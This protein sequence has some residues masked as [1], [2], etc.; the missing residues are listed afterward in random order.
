MKL[1][2]SIASMYP[3]ETE[4]SLEFLGKNGVPVTEIFFNSP[5]ELEPRF[6]SL[7]NKIRKTHGIEIASIHPCGSVAEPYFLFS[8]YKRRYEEAFDFYKKYYLAAQKLGAGTVVIHGDSYAGSIPAEEYCRRL[9]AMNEEAAKYGVTISHENVN[10]FRA[11][12]PDFVKAL[13][14]MSNNAIKYTFDIKQAV[15]AGFGVFDM[16][17]AMRRNVI[18]VH[19]S[20]HSEKGDCLLPGQGT[21]DFKRLFSALEA[22]GFDGA[23]LIEVY[24]GAYNEYCELLDSLNFVKKNHKIC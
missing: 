21:F 12:S 18:N 5:C 7:L 20:D 23:C 22:D 16:Y 4:K 9:M 15:R 10:R 2:I 14:E 6:T 17:N 1:G 8:E 24:R 19:I 13:S 3:L 11:A